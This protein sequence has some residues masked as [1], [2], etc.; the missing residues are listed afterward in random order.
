MLVQVKPLSDLEVKVMDL[1]NFIM[2]YIVKVLHSRFTEIYLLN[3][4]MDFAFIWTD[5]RY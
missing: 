3:I 2:F 5:V 4:L 1:K